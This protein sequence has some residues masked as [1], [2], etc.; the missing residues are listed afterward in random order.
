VLWA[1]ASLNFFLPRLAP[2]NPV[3]ERLLSAASEGGSLQGGI[4]EMVRAYNEQF[5]LDKPLWVQY[6]RYMWHVAHLDFGYSIANYP[7]KVA[8]MILGALPWTLGLLTLSALIA[9]V[10]GTL[11]GALIAWPRAPRVFQYLIVP[12]ITLSAIPYFLLGLVLI[13]IFGIALPLLPLSGG[14]SL[15]AIPHF[16]LPFIL[17]ILRHMFLPSLSIVLASA[18]F[19]SLGMRGMM[20][21]TKGEDYI[22]FA[23]AK[24]LRDRRIFLNY[25]VRNAILPQVTSF[26]INLG[27][28]IGGSVIVEVIFGYP[29]I[30]SLLYSAIAGS[31]YFVIYGIVYMTV[32]A[33]AIAT[34]LIDLIYP[35]LD[36]RISY[37][38]A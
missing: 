17:D 30:G 35:I 7:A 9:F 6:G 3:R 25:A 15:G 5:G 14:Y 19:W 29:G 8:T 34:L 20:I 38:R 10:L 31:D 36:P 12:M 13:Y 28:I 27:T 23:E 16:N 26:A 24:G 22:N 21:T 33:I 18:G 1:A 32:L 11:L 2:G 37:M 4:E